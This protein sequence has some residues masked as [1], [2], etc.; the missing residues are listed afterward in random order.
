MFYF[1]GEPMAPKEYK[2]TMAEHAL[3]APIKD[4]GYPKKKK[5]EDYG[6]L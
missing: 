1:S 2:L 5:T 3:W 4:Q 6:Q